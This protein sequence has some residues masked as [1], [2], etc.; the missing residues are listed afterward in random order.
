MDNYLLAL[1]DGSEQAGGRGLGLEYRRPKRPVP[2]TPYMQMLYAPTERRLDTAI[3]RALFASSTR[4]ARQLVVHGD[5]HVN[6]K[7]VRF[8]STTNLQATVFL[9][10]YLTVVT[11]D[12]PSLQMI[13]PGY[14][15]N[16]G[17]MFQVD[18]DRVLYATGAGKDPIDRRLGRKFRNWAKRQAKAPTK[19]PATDEK[20][21]EEDGPSEEVGETSD[22]KVDTSKPRTAST[23]Q[24]KLSALLLRAQDVMKDSTMKVPA[25]RRQD[26]RSFQRAVRRAMS[27]PGEQTSKV[28]DMNLHL[29]EILS[30]LSSSSS[31]SFPSSSSPSTSEPGS[32][33]T[34]TDP[35]TMIN[36]SAAD[37]KA[38]ILA[39]QEAR[40]NPFDPSKPYATP[41][42]PRDYMSPFAFIPRY[43]EVNQNVCSA[44]YLRHPVARPGSAE[45]PTP[46]AL[47]ENQLAHNWYLRRR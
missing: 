28:G 27:R 16:P 9:G 36:L 44:V 38:L 6:G 11:V 4:Q 33:S 13:Y 20:E 30:K 46:F 47:N 37:R 23:P 2:K 8:D 39:L 22:K 41:W 34:L 17:D 19:R 7:K 31:S 35:S 29:E 14:L 15:L 25:K 5:V 3:F 24:Q 40:D 26:L 45:V 32:T 1:Q 21:K 42:R 12:W 10:S 43:L 18:P